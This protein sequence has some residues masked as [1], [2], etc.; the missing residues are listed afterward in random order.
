[1]RVPIM[2]ADH[3]VGDELRAHSHA[4][5]PLRDPAL[6][7]W[8]APAGSAGMVVT[9][10]TAVTYS[11]VFACVRAIAESIGAMPLITYRRLEGD[12]RER[13]REEPAYRLLRARP[14]S[15]MSSGTLRELLT[16]HTLLHGNGYAEIERDQ[17]GRP[18]ALWPMLPGVCQ[19]SRDA[20]G[21]LFYAV[22]KSDGTEGRLEAADVLHLRGLGGDGIV[23]WS[24]IR[25][26][27]ESIGLGLAAQAYGAR[28]FGSDGRPGGV[29]EYPGKLTDK[30]FE[31]LR[32]GW[33]ERHGAGR[34]HRLAIL[35][36]GVKYTA[37]SVPPEEAQFLESRQFQI[38]D[39]ARWFRVQP[40]KIQHLARST[41]NNI[42]H[43]GLEFVYDTLLPWL[44]RWEDEVNAKLLGGVEHLYAE[45]LV[46]H[47]LR[48]DTSS[49]Y[50]AYA[51]GRQWGWLSVDDIRTRENMNP[52]PAGQGSI[53]LIPGNMVA[54]DQ[55]PAPPSADVLL[56]VAD[57]VRR[58]EL[59]TEAA[60]ELVLLV[61]PT[62]SRER[63]AKVLAEAAAAKPGPSPTTVP[64][65]PAAAAAARDQVFSE[66]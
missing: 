20:A 14:N 9:P 10:D 4:G 13:A 54:A 60:V 48:A 36:D 32:R 38:E 66:D 26:A 23:G 59:S 7:D 53:Y 1:M 21:V 19:P 2:P 50:Q 5:V 42:E 17:A 15:E 47:Q 57:A 6:A 44:I 37:L 24:P 3:A 43:Q 45:H 61:A 56:R 62:V 64:P 31:N 29:L 16:A 30:A 11:A 65:D 40:H 35:E 12:A 51:T 55:V 49:R 22:R 33:E 52:L 18:L 41:N 58:G 34:S 27:R 46:D 63:I 25:L 8:W 28:F 39:V